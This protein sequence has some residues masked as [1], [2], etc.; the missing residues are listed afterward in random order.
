M[1]GSPHNGANAYAKIGIETGVLAASPHQLTAMLFDGALIALVAAEQHMKDGEIPEK[2]KA[3]SKAISIIE[4][5]LRASLNKKVGGELAQNLDALY[6]YMSRRLLEANV[7]NDPK[8]IE[9]IH[10]LLKDLK[11]SW[12]A[13]RPDA[14]AARTA[15]PASP[16]RNDPLE[17]RVPHLAKA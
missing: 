2:G 5:G 8:I 12:D 4:E 11:A 15:E 14:T 13:I 10:G 16:M 6:E 9:E 7:K 1:F 3:I 17:P